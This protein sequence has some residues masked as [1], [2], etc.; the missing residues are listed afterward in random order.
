[1]KM[2]ELN[3]T[4]PIPSIILHLLHRVY[5]SCVCRDTAKRTSC[6]CIVS[7]TGVTET[8]TYQRTV[9]KR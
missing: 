5:R 4:G 1:M 7:E 8:K 6:R 9:I 3:K 2:K